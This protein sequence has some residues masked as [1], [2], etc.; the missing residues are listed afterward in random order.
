M[1]PEQA[2][3]KTGLVD[4]RSDLWSVGAT[5]FALLTGR[6][7]HEGETPQHMM[8]LAATARAPSVATLSRFMP[9]PAA[10]LIDRALAFDQAERW[11]SALAMDEALC[12]LYVAL[13]GE[14][15]SRAPLVGLASRTASPTS[16]L[17]VTEPTMMSPGNT[18]LIGDTT[19]AS[20]PVEV[21]S[22]VREPPSIGSDG[23]GEARSAAPLHVGR[24]TEQPV[25]DGKG[26]ST[27]EP[28]R[29][30]W[31][32]VIGGA[33]VVVGIGILAALRQFSSPP[34]MP[35]AVTA[36]PNDGAVVVP[37]PPVAKEIVLPPL[38]PLEPP[39]IG[40]AGGDV[41]GGA[42]APRRPLPRSGPRTPS[43]DTSR[44]RSPKPPP[45][46]PLPGGA[47]DFDRQ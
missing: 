23:A 3:G 4:G 35:V 34:A 2:L 37:A 40:A 43:V 44:P 36:A 19:V 5:M 6:D 21:D 39:A 11:P 7:V 41:D 46:A 8:V 13:F 30:R 28:P 24:T 33:V 1:A 14:P 10:A 17:E 29:N 42:T 47:N 20:S 18:P 25:S 16:L 9:A 15:I 27:W 12:S 26:D 45:G 32:V 22:R 38:E 31:P